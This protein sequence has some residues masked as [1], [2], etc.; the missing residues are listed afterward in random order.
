MNKALLRLFFLVP[1]VMMGIG[2]LGMFGD[3]LSAPQPVQDYM[4]WYLSQP[5]SPIYWFLNKIAVLGLIG[6]GLS[7]FGLLF[8]WSPARYC[9][10]ASIIFALIGEVTDLPVLVVGWEGLIDNI[11]KIAVGLNIG[12]MFYSPARTL[13]SSG[14]K[15]SA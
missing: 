11:L 15:K 9:Y 1:L 14:T 2:V 6:I 4:H 8:F 10:V 3:S 7:T 5:F 12:L 13:F